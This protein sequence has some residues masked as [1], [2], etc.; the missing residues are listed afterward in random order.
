ML[1]L[2]L[3]YA[4]LCVAEWRTAEC[5]VE[6]EEVEEARGEPSRGRVACSLPNRNKEIAGEGCQGTIPLVDYYF[7]GVTKI[8]HVVG[9]VAGRG[10][11]PA[12]SALSEGLI[13]YTSQNTFDIWKALQ[14]IDALRLDGHSF[15]FIYFCD[16]PSYHAR[17]I[18]EIFFATLRRHR[19]ILWFMFQSKHGF[20]GPNLLIKSLVSIWKLHAVSPRK[21]EYLS[22]FQINDWVTPL[23]TCNYWK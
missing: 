9:K 1:I 4:E 11:Y 14:V 8:L 15:R 16:Y 23:L 18:F 2:E 13:F 10:C 3:S 22:R 20:F 6:G 19:N 5:W 12:N 7:A 17:S 21:T